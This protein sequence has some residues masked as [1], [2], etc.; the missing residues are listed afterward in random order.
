MMQQFPFS[1]TGF[2]NKVDSLHQMDQAYEK[3]V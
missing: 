1:L 2:M 3:I